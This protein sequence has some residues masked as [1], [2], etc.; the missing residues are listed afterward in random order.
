MSSP[1]LLGGCDVQMA[2]DFGLPRE[3]PL[4]D[5]VW[6]LYGEV[7]GWGP[8]GSPTR[9]TGYII[10][11]PRLYTGGFGE[12]RSRKGE[13]LLSF[14]LFDPPGPDGGGCHI[15]MYGSPAA[16]F[17]EMAAP[18]DR[19]LTYPKVLARRM[20]VQDLR[21]RDTFYLWE[22]A[23]KPRHHIQ[24][25][26]VPVDGGH[27]CQLAVLVGGEVTTRTLPADLWVDVVD[28]EREPWIT[29]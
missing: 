13:P 3:I 19:P 2:F 23:G 17:W 1:T 6:G 21:V 12:K 24:A 7:K 20:P 11:P 14:V 27:R 25:D 16:T 22:Q 9:H 5:A 4:A 8:D 26:P 29:R 10:K 15:G 18:A 28:P